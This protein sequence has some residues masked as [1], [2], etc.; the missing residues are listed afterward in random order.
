MNTENYLQQIKEN[1]RRVGELL[2][3]QERMK[4]MPAQS[5]RIAADVTALEAQIE[6]S[7]R[8]NRLA[9]KRA[10]RSINKLPDGLERR[11]LTLFYL[12]HLRIQDIA[13]ILSLTPRQLYR[14]KRRALLH[15]DALNV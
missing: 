4:D 5:T 10:L 6:A 9:R 15:L 11:A 2:R 3:L 8:D 14:V 13:L 1:D 12:Q 7:M